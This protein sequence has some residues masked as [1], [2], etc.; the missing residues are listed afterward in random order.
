MVGPGSEENQRLNTRKFEASVVIT[1]T[2]AGGK[3]F[4]M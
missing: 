4:M 2:F 3:Q 1:G